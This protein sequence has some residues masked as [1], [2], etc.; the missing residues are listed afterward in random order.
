MSNNFNLTLAENETKLNDWCYATTRGKTV[1][2][3]QL[4]VTDKRIIDLSTKKY[5]NGDSVRLAEIPSDNVCGLSIARSSQSFIP[6]AIMFGIMA[7]VCLVVFLLTVIKTEPEFGYV[8]Q[9]VLDLGDAGDVFL[10]LAIL[11]C[12]VAVMYALKGSHSLTIVISVKNASVD[13]IGLYANAGVVLKTKKK[14]LKVKVDKN[15]SD[16]IYDTLGSLLLTK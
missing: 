10:I 15:A 16:E 6:K 4:I 11:L 13:T 7:F 3:H 9:P 5:K 2:R 14:S 8:A 1:S 12:V